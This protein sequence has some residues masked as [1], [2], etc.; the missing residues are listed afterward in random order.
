M[1]RFNFF[2]WYPASLSLSSSFNPPTPLQ[3]NVVD[4]SNLGL[5]PPSNTDEMDHNLK[6]VRTYD[7]IFDLSAQNCRQDILLTISPLV[8]SIIFC[9]LFT[10]AVFI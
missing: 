9:L 7:M 6:L 2:F 5:G 10:S 3:N 4:T 1:G 8:V